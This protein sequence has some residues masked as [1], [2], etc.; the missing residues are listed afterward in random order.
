MLC[1]CIIQTDKSSLLPPIFDLCVQEKLM[2]WETT[3]LP[4]I[5]ILGIFLSTLTMYLQK[6]EYL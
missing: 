6:F 3:S 5:A 1:H 2:Q 4:R